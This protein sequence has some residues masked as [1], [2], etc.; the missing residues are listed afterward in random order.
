MRY[1]TV[2]SLAVFI[3]TPVTA[4]DVP[5]GCY[6]RDYSDEHLAKYPEQ[7]VDRISI[8][9]G[10]YEGIVWAD[11]KVLLADQGHA[12]RDG[13]GGR[14]LSETAGNFNEPLEFGVE[15]DGGSFDIVSFD[16]DTIEIET[17]RFRLSVDGCGGEET[18]SDL[19]ET[20]SSSTT[21]TLNRSK[22]GACF[23]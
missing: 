23:W 1:L 8:M 15:C 3:A 10:P 22:L 6:V 5:V 19:L 16:M 13:I 7:V 14:Y 9:F 18:Y 21:Y 4:Q 11:V 17:R 20:G 12:S 2:L